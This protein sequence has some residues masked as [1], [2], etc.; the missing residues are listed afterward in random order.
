MI[1]FAKAIRR[2]LLNEIDTSNLEKAV[3]A[4]A[5]GLGVDLLLTA[6]HQ[7]GILKYWNNNVSG[8]SYVIDSVLKSYFPDG[9]ATIFDAGANIGDYSKEIKKSFPR[10]KIYAFEPNINTFKS[11][12]DKLSSTDIKRFCVGLGSCAS[13]QKLYTYAS[14]SESQHASVYKEVLSDLHKADEILEVEFET[15]SLDEFCEEH[16]IETVDFL[17]IDTEGHELEV[18]VGAKKKISEGKIGIIQFEFNEMNIISR[19]FLKDF[20]DALSNYN[21]YRIDSKRLIPLFNYDSSNEIFKFQNF[22]AVKK[23]LN[24]M[25]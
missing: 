24:Y 7:R 13:R 20:Y 17:K 6:Y 12:D 2:R 21:I 19:V 18:I 23:S 15:V 1:G 4:L 5:T 16:E 8:E 3:V 14:D 25:N 11:L 9:E 22:L 10:S